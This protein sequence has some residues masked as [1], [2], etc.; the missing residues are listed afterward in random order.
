MAEREKV[1]AGLKCHANT[2]FDCENCPYLSISSE[3]KLCSEVLAG[4]ALDLLEKQEQT[5]TSLQSTINKLNEGIR[6][7]VRWD[8]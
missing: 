8:G 6:K 1:F 2:T 5:V 3:E 4:D 7:A